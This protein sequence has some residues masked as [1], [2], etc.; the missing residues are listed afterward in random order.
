MRIKIAI[1][2][3]MIIGAVLLT[4]A[5]SELKDPLKKPAIWKRLILEPYDSATW[6]SYI[7]KPWVTLNV[8]ERNFVKKIQHYIVQLKKEKSPEID[9]FENN[10]KQNE[11]WEVD[12]SEKKYLEHT[13][14]KFWESQKLQSFEYEQVFKQ[15][16]LKGH[17][18]TKKLETNINSNFF[19]IEDIYRTEFKKLDITY[20]SY[21]ETYPNADF[22]KGEWVENKKAELLEYRKKVIKRSKKN[23]K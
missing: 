13:E 6:V 8:K 12:T 15:Y 2:I 5:N 23:K 10:K 7:E 1:L 21:L 11:L 4:K 22:D 3:I 9:P 20:M 19:L 16:L 17:D 14:K 18:I